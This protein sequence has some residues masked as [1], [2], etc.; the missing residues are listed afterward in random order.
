M[1]T[2]TTYQRDQLTGTLE[3]ALFFVI[4]LLIALASV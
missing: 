4:L 3:A 1:E 2:K